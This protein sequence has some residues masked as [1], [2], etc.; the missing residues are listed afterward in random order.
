MLSA[1][2]RMSVLA[3]SKDQADRTESSPIEKEVT[4]EARAQRMEIAAAA[5]GDRMRVVLERHFLEADRGD[6]AAFL[7]QEQE[8]FAPVSAGIVVVD[9]W[10]VGEAAPRPKMVRDPVQGPE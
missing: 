9:K 5:D 1:Q 4:P 10:A 3:A 2:D 7:R 8:Q 6:R